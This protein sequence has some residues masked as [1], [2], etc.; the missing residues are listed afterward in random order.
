M[1]EHFVTHQLW[2]LWHIEGIFDFGA[3]IDHRCRAEPPR[4]HTST[5]LDAQVTP[6]DR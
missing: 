2:I 4:G 3:R 1:R 6:A 5:H